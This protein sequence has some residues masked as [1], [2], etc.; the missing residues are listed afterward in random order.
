MPRLFYAISVLGVTRGTFTGP[1]GGNRSGRDTA[2]PRGY[3]GCRVSHSSL[4]DG[5]GHLLAPACSRDTPLSAGS[6]G[7]SSPLHALVACSFGNTGGSQGALRSTGSRWV[8]LP[9]GLVAEVV[10]GF[11]ILLT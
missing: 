11:G 8:L 1:Q 7:R 10:D 5:A 2:V 6:I 4:K 9:L 3:R